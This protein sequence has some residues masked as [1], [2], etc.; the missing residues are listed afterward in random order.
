[1]VAGSDA[2]KPG[3]PA[4]D[5][6]R[7]RAALEAE[8]QRLENLVADLDSG[9]DTAR[10]DAVG[11]LT[12]YDQHQADAGTE[13][14]EREKDESIRAGFRDQLAEVRA[15]L[16]R[17]ADGTYGIDEETGEPIDPERLA[18]LPTARTNVRAGAP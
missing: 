12:S 1:M 14:F 8:Q 17:I 4:L 11:D 13:T 5:L 7:A 9:L 10:T 18:A 16:E 15:A 3:S 2:P 6:E